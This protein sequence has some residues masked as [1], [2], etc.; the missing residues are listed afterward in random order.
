MRLPISSKLA[1]FMVSAGAA[2][3]FTSLPSAAGPLSVSPGPSVQ[4][5]AVQLVHDR[6]WRRRHRHYYDDTYV[7]APFTRVERRR[8]RVAVDAPFASV[9]TGRRGTWVRAPFVDLFVPR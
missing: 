2:V 4:E 8:S 5:S 1:A 7:D 3:L 6:Y 9:R